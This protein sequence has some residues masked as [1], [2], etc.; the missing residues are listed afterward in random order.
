MNNFKAQYSN[1]KIVDIPD[2]NTDNFG[3][4]LAITISLKA[5]KNNYWLFTDADCQP[6]S[7]YW[8]NEMSTGFE[9]E[10]QI[11]IGVGI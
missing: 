1:L 11:V 10:K 5:A 9:G 6:L 3:K 8:I 2:N 4:K 7:E